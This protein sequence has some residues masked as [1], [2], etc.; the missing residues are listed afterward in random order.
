M[1]DGGQDGEAVPPWQTIR[2]GH[3]TI[4]SYGGLVRI[5]I[6]TCWAAN[7][8]EVTFTLDSAFFNA[9]NESPYI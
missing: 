7:V 2:T 3:W 1:P 5:V 9:E 8:T 4:F 6:T